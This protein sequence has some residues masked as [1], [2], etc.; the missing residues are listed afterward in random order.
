VWVLD[1]INNEGFSGGPVVFQTGTA[2]KI[3]AVV[4]GMLMETVNVDSA[5]PESNQ[6][7]PK[8]TVKENAGFIFA[9]DIQY[10]VDVIKKNPIG[11]LRDKK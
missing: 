4:S 6:K 8:E 11:P 7:H 5:D 3:F 1:G 9:F 10:A 2:Q